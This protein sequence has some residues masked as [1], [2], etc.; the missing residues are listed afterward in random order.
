MTLDQMRRY[1]ELAAQ[2]QAA[3]PQLQVL[4]EAQEHALGERLQQMQRHLKYVRGK[5]AYWRAI[6]A[7][8]EQAV[9]DILVQL[10]SDA[11]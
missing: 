3:A 7:R 11:P 5:L 4:L 6:A 8:D 10:A 9:S 1:L 2:S